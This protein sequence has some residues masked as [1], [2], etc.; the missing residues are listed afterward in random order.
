MIIETKIDGRGG[1]LYHIKPLKRREIPLGWFKTEQEAIDSYLQAHPEIANPQAPSG[2][3]VDEPNING[4]I[5]EQKDIDKICV[6]NN[7]KTIK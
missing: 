5:L 4:R 3:I 1:T 6:D 2:W 7:R